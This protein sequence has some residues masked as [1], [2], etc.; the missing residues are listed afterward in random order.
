[1]NESRAEGWLITRFLF[2]S[3]ESV[4]VGQLERDWLDFTTTRLIPELLGLNGWG[5]A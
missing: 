5:E 1:M 4:N 2:T 3:G